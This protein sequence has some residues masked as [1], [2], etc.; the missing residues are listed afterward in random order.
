VA[1]AFPPP[2][3]TASTLQGA[4]AVMEQIDR[5]LPQRDGLASFNRMYLGV[6]RQVSARI[7]QGFF[8]NAEFLSALEVVFANMYFDAVNAMVTTP[9]AIPTAWRPLFEARARPDIYS[10][11]FSLAGMNAHINHD[12]PMALVRACTQLNTAP[13]SGTNHRDYQRVDALL[14]AAELSVRHTFESREVEKADRSVQTVLDLVDNW[15][16]TAARH[17]AWSTGQALWRCRGD[18]TVEDLIMSSLASAVSLSSRCLLTA[19]ERDI[20]IPITAPCDRVMKS[21]GVLL[22]G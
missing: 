3:T 17:M 18:T 13:E 2:C 15:S 11:Q 22:H 7:E 21:F 6:T 9:N 8:H 12:L 19:P 14:E 4:I 5:S 20:H 10:I 1:I 16:I